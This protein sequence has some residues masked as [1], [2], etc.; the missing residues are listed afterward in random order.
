MSTND[1]DNLKV[2]GFANIIINLAGIL[3]KM[4]LALPEILA[5]LITCGKFERVRIDWCLTPSRRGNGDIVIW[6]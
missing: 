1:I 6:S 2:S 4:F 5:N 3:P